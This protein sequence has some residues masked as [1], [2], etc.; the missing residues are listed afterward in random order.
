M[1][2]T[3]DMVVNR[4]MDPNGTPDLVFT[5]YLIPE[6]IDRLASSAQRSIVVLPSK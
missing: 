1:T 5:E 6:G 4:Q 3:S 2:T